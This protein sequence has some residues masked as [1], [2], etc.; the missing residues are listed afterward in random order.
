MKF[1]VVN[2]NSTKAVAHEVA[3][4]A[5]VRQLGIQ[6]QLLYSKIKHYGIDE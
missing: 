6:R 3:I 5:A 4:A 1:P 2:P